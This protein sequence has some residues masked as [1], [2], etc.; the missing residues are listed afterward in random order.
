MSCGIQLQFHTRSICGAMPTAMP[1]PRLECM[2]ISV[3]Q[4]ASAVRVTSGTNCRASASL[5]ERQ[6][7]VVSACTGRMGFT[8]LHCGSFKTVAD[9]FNFSKLTCEISSRREGMVLQTPTLK[10]IIIETRADSVKVK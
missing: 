2:E 5:A 8:L 9:F 10:C 6:D 3:L 7:T 4:W 1:H